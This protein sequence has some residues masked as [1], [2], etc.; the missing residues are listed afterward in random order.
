M[1]PNTDLTQLEQRDVALATTNTNL[2]FNQ[3]LAANIGSMGLTVDDFPR[4][5]VP[6]GGETNWV[7]SGLT[8][9]LI[10]AAL[11]GIIVF[12]RTTRA[13]WKIE[14]D[15]PK[16]AKNTPPNCT[17]ING[18]VGVG[19]PGGCCYNLDKRLVC[20][21]AGYGTSKGGTG[22]G[23]ACK[24]VTQLFFLRGDSMLPELIALPPTSVK[25]ARK[26][27]VRLTASRVPYFAMLTRI[28]LIKKESANG[29][30]YAVAQLDTVRPLA[31]VELENAVGFNRLIGPML[32]S[33]AAD[34]E[35]AS[36]SAF[37]QVD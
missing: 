13:Y 23:Q 17:S 10:M 12:K 20:P 28:T 16:A 26:Y 9:P 36:E 31:G 8:G 35:T 2:A 32:Q 14:A 37:G 21:L 33:A 30:P 11:E 29:K 3:A 5:K 22:P 1:V 7:L 4:I 25:P 34:T 18:L 15:D 6:A 24:E 27:F 19:D